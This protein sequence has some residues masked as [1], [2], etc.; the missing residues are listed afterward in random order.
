MKKLKAIWFASIFF[1]AFFPS[2]IFAEEKSYVIGVED[3]DHLPY[4]KGEKIRYEGFSRVLLDRFAE[5]QHYRFTYRP[6]PIKRLF[7]DFVKQKFDFKY[8]DNPGWSAD[9][10]KGKNIRYSTSAVSVVTGVMVLPENRTRPLEKF[11]TLGCMM[12]YTVSAYAD[13]IKAGKV[14]KVEV[15]TTDFASLLKMAKLKRVDGVYITVDVGNYHLREIV[16]DPDAL[17]FNPSLPYDVYKF[18]LSSIKHPEV[19]E[20]FDEFMTEEKAFVEQLK[21]EHHIMNIEKFKP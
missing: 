4:Y 13:L 19:I 8:P 2:G 14:R 1:L 5:K 11:R 20:E 15:G 9:M 10:K 6:L 16:K 18:S 7:R 3:I 17:I 12:G 21:K